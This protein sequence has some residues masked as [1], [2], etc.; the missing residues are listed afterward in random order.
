MFKIILIPYRTE[1]EGKNLWKE[2]ENQSTLVCPFLS[3]LTFPFPFPL[4]DLLYSL[5]PLNFNHKNTIFSKIGK[6]WQQSYPETD[7]NTLQI[8]S[9]AKCRCRRPIPQRGLCKSEI[10]NLDWKREKKATLH[11]FTHVKC[12]QNRFYSLISFYFQSTQS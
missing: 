7:T 9:W 3:P 10:Q 4:P 12:L 11:F 5:S 1:A 2:E 6:Y 8:G